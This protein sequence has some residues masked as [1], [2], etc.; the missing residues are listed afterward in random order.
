ME[1][2]YLEILNKSSFHELS[3]EEKQIISELCTSEDEFEDVK[4]LYMGLESL[5]NESFQMNSHAVKSQLDSEFKEVHGAEGGFKIL[6]FLFPSISPF[7]AKPGLQIAFLLVFVVSLYFSIQY[8]SIDKN[9]GVLHSQNTT[10]EKSIKGEEES[11]VKPLEKEISSEKNK[12]MKMDGTTL[13]SNNNGS[14][15]SNETTADIMNLEL[16]EA[17]GWILDDNVL[18]M[19]ASPSPMEMTP[20]AKS[21]LRMDNEAPFVIEPIGAHIELI[22]DLF[23][24]F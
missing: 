15:K 24:T 16:E 12:D 19:A 1:N 4:H 10:A 20:S 3:I 18:S 8:I 21:A 7:Y 5:K 2:R 14:F 22:E 23:V 17:G 6:S 9:Q 11:V 13:S